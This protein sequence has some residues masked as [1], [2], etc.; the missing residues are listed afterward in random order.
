[1]TF[2]FTSLSQWLGCGARLAVAAACGWLLA[3]SAAQ[4]QCTE[5]VWNDEFDTPGNLSKWQVYEGDGC[6]TGLC[7]FGN[8][9]LQVYR[10]ANATVAGGYLSIAT[11]YENSVQGGRTYN[12]TSAKLLSK[13]AS[14]GLKTFRYGRIEA[15]MKLPS[16]QGVWPAFWMLADP[17]NW[18]F[19]GEIDIM[20][21]KHKNPRSVS[22]T[23]HYDAGGWR[24]TG[25]DY[26]APVDLSQDFHVYAVEWSPDQIK[27]FVDGNLFHTAS[28]KTT[29]GNSWPFNDGNFYLILNTAV[30]GPGTGFTGLGLN[31]TP[32]DYPVTTQVD[33][34]RVYK[35]TYNYAILGPGQVYQGDQNRTF[36]LDAVGSGAIYTWSVPSGATVVSG[37]GT[38]AVQVNFG[39][40]AV[41]GAVTAT[42]TVNG[43][44]TATYTKSVTVAPALQL[45]RVYEDFESNRVLA[46]GAATGT[47]TP[48][49]DNPSAVINTSAKVGR[50]VRNATEQ[51]DVLNVKNLGI[52]NANDFVAGRRRV[53]VDVYSTAP[54]GSKVTLQLENSNV[55]TAINFPAGRHSAYRAFTSRQN[56]W[57]TL[58]FEL[59]KVLD[60][61]TNIYS[62]NNVAL[63]FQP[64]TNSGATFYFDNVVIRKQPEAPVVATEALLNYDGAA[65]LTFDAATTNGVYSAGVANPAAGGANTS[66]NVGKYVRNASE[67]YDVLFFNA[68]AP[69]TVVEDAGLFKNQTYQFQLDVYTSAPVGTPINITLQNKALAAPTGSFPAGRNSTYLANTTKQNQWET[70]TFS[71]NTAPDAG[72]AN[73]SIDQLAVLFNSGVKSG[74]TYYI[75]NLRI[76][77]KA[78]PTYSAG[79]TLENY[80]DV[81]NLSFV[82]AT[83]TYQ[84]AVNN[85]AS[86]GANTSAKV[87]QYT[88]NSASTYDALTLGT[89][90]IKDGAAY[91]AGRKVFALDV[92]TSAPVGTVVSWQL[93]SSAASTPGNFP[94]GRHSVYHAVVKQTNAWH[95]LIFSYA[96]SPDASTPDAD[97]DNVVLLFAP[98]SST[99][100]VFYV[101]NLRT[102]SASGAAPN[103][104]PTVSLTA[105][106]NNASFTAPA[107]IPLTAAAA[108][109]DGT[110]SK[111]EFF[112][113]STKLGE[114]TS[115]PFTYTWSGVAAGS[116]SLTAKATDNQGATATS[117]AVAV[118]VS[119]APV[120]QAIP[121][122]IQA[123]SYVAMSG[124]DTEPTTDTGGGRNMNWFETGDWVDYDVNVATAGTY[125]VGFRVASA[126]GGAQL[127]LRSSAGA[128]LA[129]ISVGNTGGWQSWTTISATASLPA[130]GQR[131][132]LYAQASSGCNV[133]WLSF[134]ATPTD[135]A[136]PNLAL[137]KPV[138]VS[139]TENAQVPG[140]AAVDGNGGTRWASAFA[141]SQWLYVDLGASYSISRVKLTWEAAY[142][143]DYRVEVSSD[144]QNWTPLKTITGNTSLVNDHTGLSGTGQYVRIY[145]TAR[146]TAYGYSL[147]ELEVYGTAASSSGSTACTGTVAN[148][149]YSYEVSTTNGTVNWKFVPLAPIAGSSLA[150]IYVKVGSGGYTGYPMTAAGGNFT[151]AQAQ[152]GGAALSFYFTYRVGTT[153]AERNSSAT[154]HAYTAGT[155]CAANRTAARTTVPAALAYPN[156]VRNRLTVPTAEAATL[157]IT[158]SRGRVVQRVEVKGQQQATEVDVHSLPPG[159]YFLTLRGVRGPAT[160]QQFVKE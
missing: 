77:K 52:G 139:S 8:A 25:R 138:T 38:N 149:D 55:T 44:T 96:S 11:R 90:L 88:R 129:T 145:G 153:T 7:N 14:G 50:Y 86:G 31:P 120:A 112:Q 79:A 42:V 34:V 142:G 144:R 150:L 121:G 78:T 125:T 106:A 89:S 157:T 124:V 72:T 68:G 70:L 65:R 43:C 127:Q 87:A 134:T 39:S 114:D 155:T 109:A 9:E 158:N 53:F 57:E 12:Y 135:P 76:A 140:S 24:F 56:A 17:G 15:R 2:T 3:P 10:A 4:A 36:R 26:N 102:L 108:D 61:G 5:L 128:V 117:A 21:A 152:A 47:L 84:A 151:F 19:T 30:G 100:T 60:A 105:P 113:G 104:P 1:M 51:Y 29:A 110:V 136:T 48:V 49:V 101:D 131:L 81:R 28:P 133:N 99:G 103:T 23:I 141:D 67:Q 69:G 82:R 18:P 58:E 73:V 126:V 6:E 54:V 22:G 35:G 98:N 93:E 118:T 95:T 159:L 146:G 80:D 46:Y 156:P 71:F 74:D 33:Y 119:A 123:E 75:D 111:V 59:E 147:Y 66:A 62:I 116:Y 94:A 160:V 20:E 107:S 63:L 40:G 137:N 115:A 148:G 41:S 83:G 154:P 130:G 143:R 32:A 85:P 122:T 27:W 91:V 97:V 64:A 37:Q 132:R 92:Y 45:D 16:A 13:Q